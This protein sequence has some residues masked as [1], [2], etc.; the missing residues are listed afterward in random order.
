MP[1][2]AQLSCGLY[3]RVNGRNG[4]AGRRYGRNG[5]VDSHTFAEFVRHG[6]EVRLLLRDPGRIAPALGPL[7]IGDVESRPRIADRQ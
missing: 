5:V 4:I 3:A 7:G 1:S 2:A 6:H